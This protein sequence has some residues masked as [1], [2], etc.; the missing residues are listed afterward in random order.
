MAQNYLNLKLKFN[1]MNKKSII[2]D[3]HRYRIDGMEA[4]TYLLA[5]ATVSLIFYSVYTAIN[6]VF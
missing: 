6:F 3:E 2:K 1:T 5:T 4:I